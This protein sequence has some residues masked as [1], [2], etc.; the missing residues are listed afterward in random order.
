M[1]VKIK[2]YNK[3]VHSTVA[4][5]EE[6][7]KKVIAVLATTFGPRAEAFAGDKDVTSFYMQSLKSA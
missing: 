3:V 4:P 7:A 5:D 1:I 2:M 6:S